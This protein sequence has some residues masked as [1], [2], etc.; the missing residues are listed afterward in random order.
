MEAL[1]PYLLQE[2]ADYIDYI[3]FKK[4]KD[5]NL[6]IDDITLAS[7]KSLAKDWLDPEEDKAWENL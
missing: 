2:V 3:E 6:E 4:N 7:E 1:P 5:R